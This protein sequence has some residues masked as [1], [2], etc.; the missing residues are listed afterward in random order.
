MLDDDYLKIA[1]DFTMHNSVSIFFL[2]SSMF[3][4]VIELAQTLTY[5]QNVYELYFLISVLILRPTDLKIDFFKEEFKKNSV[6]RLMEMLSNEAN[7]FF[8]NI[9][10][11]SSCKKFYMNKLIVIE[12]FSFGLQVLRDISS[13]KMLCNL[14]RMNT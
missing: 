4:T 12:E 10:M 6:K 5:F 7:L 8:K 14:M 11:T 2:C 9:D 13:L 1:D 3:K